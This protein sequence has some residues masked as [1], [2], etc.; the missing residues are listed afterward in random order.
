ME[1]HGMALSKINMV[2]I[3]QE[4]GVHVKQAGARNEKY[5][6]AYTEYFRNEEGKARNR[7][8]SIGKFDETTGKMLPN[9]NYFERYRVEP[10]LSGSVRMDYGYAYLVLKACRDTGLLKCLE[11]AFGAAAAMDIVVIAAY[12]VREGNA[13]DGIDDWQERNCFP[14]YRKQL[15]SQAVS[16]CFASYAYNR[17][18]SFFRRWIETAL[19]GGTVCYDVTSVSSYSAG[20]AT[21]ERGY[22][23]DGDDLAQ[24]NLGMFCDE[25][26]RMPLYYNRYNGSLTDKTNLANVLANAGEVGIRNVKMILDGGFWAEECLKSLA[27]ACDAF[28]IGLPA[29]LDI[30]K[31]MIA[32]LGPGIAGYSNKVG[33]G[34]LFCARSELCHCGVAGRILLFYDERNHLLLCE[35]L[36]EKIDRLK[37][38]LSAL[39]RYPKSKLKRYSDYFDIMKHKD[40]SGFDFC[41]KAQEIDRIRKNKG[42]FLLFTTDMTSSPADIHYYYRAKD[43]DEK[44]FDQIKI[45]MAGARIRTH[46]EETTDGKTFVTFIACLIRSYLLGRLR[47]YLTDNSTSLKKALNQMSNIEIVSNPGNEFRFLKALTKKQKQILSA[48]DAD[49]DIIDNVKNLSTLIP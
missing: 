9:A 38:E 19:T 26:S 23:R 25:T 30:S 44:I 20:M 40:G 11:D 13:M 48:F 41:A 37:A 35:A 29:S 16:K 24:Y 45:D 27:G 33:S 14:N 5:V 22:N 32:N 17:R 7:S 36:S 46:S 10:T 4:K 49:N 21:V 6:Y 39:K 31:D 8:V 3:P 43:A 12:I 15:N 1:V 47:K 34:E 28:T 2:E 18:E 42:F